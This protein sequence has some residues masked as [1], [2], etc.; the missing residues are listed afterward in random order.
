MKKMAVM[1]T[2]LSISLIACGGIQKQWDAKTPT[3]KAQIIIS[4]LQDEVGALFNA[5]LEYV[6]NN[7]QHREVWKKKIVP[8]FDVANKAINSAIQIAMTKGITPAQVYQMVQPALDS[9]KE[10]MISIGVIKKEGN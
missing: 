4:G 6:N 9:V 8:A 2:L 1:M 7:P 5:G 10:L 3:E